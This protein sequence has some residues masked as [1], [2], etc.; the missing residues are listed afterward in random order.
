VCLDESFVLGLLA[1][2]VN[3]RQTPAAAQRMYDYLVTTMGISEHDAEWFQVHGEVDVQH[4]EGA[5]RLIAR[6]AHEVDDFEPRAAEIVRTGISE[7]QSLQNFYF[8]V[9]TAA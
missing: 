4:A 7:W 9:A 8:R 3:E 6:Y 1:F 5:R 2:Y